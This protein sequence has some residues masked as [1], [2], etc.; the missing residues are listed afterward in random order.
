MSND[1]FEIVKEDVEHALV[2]ASEMMSDWER[3]RKQSSGN[4]ADSELNYIKDDLYNIFNSVKQDLADL[5]ATI[6]VAKS[7]PKKFGLN[8]A[9]IA[10]RQKFV[11]ESTDKIER[12]NFNEASKNT[13]D[14]IIDFATQQQHQQVT[15]LP[16]SPNYNIIMEQQDDHMD[17]IIGTVRNLRGMAG[18]MNTELDDQAVLLDEV[19]GMVDN[20]QNRLASARYK[21][22][23]FLRRSKGNSYFLHSSA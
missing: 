13:Q 22:N 3:L 11:N 9:K 16:P 15:S 17:S 6:D 14:M 1:P 4:K 20:T 12:S 8:S 10:A 5:Q 19:D 7:N 18:A 21:V 23:D 2:Q